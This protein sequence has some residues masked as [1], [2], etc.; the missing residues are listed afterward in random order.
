M[1][2]AICF[3]VLFIASMFAWLGKRDS[4]LLLFS[5]A[6]IMA[7]GTFYHHMTSVLGLSL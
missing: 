3:I 2:I 6:L 1:Y 4:A 5:L 7:S